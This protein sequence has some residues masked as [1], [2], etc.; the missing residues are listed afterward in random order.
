MPLLTIPFFLTLIF[1]RVLLLSNKGSFDCTMPSQIWRCCICWCWGILDALDLDLFSA[2]FFIKLSIFLERTVSL[3]DRHVSSA[4]ELGLFIRQF[5]SKYST[6]SLIS[7]SYLS[8]LSVTSEETPILEMS[9]KRAEISSKLSVKI[10]LVL[11]PANSADAAL[12]SSW[13]Q[14]KL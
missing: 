10:E 6:I 4:W 3:V 11:F 13:D 7:F 8:P 14:I 12:K 5:L 9:S 2:T 1:S